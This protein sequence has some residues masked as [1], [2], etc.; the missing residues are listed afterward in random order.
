MNLNRFSSNLGIQ[1]AHSH[2]NFKK[3]EGTGKLSTYL[4]FFCF[5]FHKSPSYS[6]EFSSAFFLAFSSLS[7]R[8]KDFIN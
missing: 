1:W 8:K 3:T 2:Y 5:L 7:S 4:L 6:T